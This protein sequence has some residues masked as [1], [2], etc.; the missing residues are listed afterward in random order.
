[1][2]SNSVFK[3][4]VDTKQWFKSAGVRAI[5]T[6]AQTFLGFV[7]TE[8]IGITQLDWVQVASVCAMAG[9]ISIVTSIA[10]IP[11]VSNST[12]GGNTEGETEEETE[13]QE[14]EGVV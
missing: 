14:N 5:K 2:F 10:G 9:V 6:M 8:T 3:S 7:G 4:S 11:E 13:G 12:S 1:M